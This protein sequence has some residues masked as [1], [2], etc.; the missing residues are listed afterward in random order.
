MKLN[1]YEIFICAIIGYVSIFTALFIIQII[2]NF[3]QW[4]WNFTIFDNKTWKDVRAMIAVFPM[5][6]M[7]GAMF[8][9]GKG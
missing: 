8:R 7:L 5:S 1:I 4:E 9:Y 3:I 2:M 6:A